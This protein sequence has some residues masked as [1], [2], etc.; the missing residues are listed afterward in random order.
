MEHNTL[1]WETNVLK[2]WSIL[3]KKKILGGSKT[4]LIASMETH[5]LSTYA[6]IQEAFF[7]RM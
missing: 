3:K 4:N 2:R 6:F 1:E 5:L 7:K